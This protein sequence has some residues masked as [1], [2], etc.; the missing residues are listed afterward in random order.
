M[1]SCLTSLG[2]FDT[3]SECVIHAARKKCAPPTLKAAIGSGGTGYGIP[4]A[5][6]VGCDVLLCLGKDGTVTEQTGA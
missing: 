5:P 1:G 2:I 3:C 6:G 4:A